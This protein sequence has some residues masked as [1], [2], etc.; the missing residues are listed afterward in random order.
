MKKLFFCVMVLS[1]IAS[2][3]TS[4]VKDK[5]NMPGTY[6]M[7]SQTLNDGTRETKF[8]DLKQLKIYTDD[9]MMYVQV[10][11][12]D[13]ISA[14]G[15]GTYTADTGTVTE[16]VI[17]SASDSNF[18]SAP[19]TFKLNITK[20]TDG[21]KQV[22]P[23]IVTDSQNYKLT[24]IYQKVGT[25]TKTPL[26]GV[27]KEV[28]SYN[29]RGKDTLKTTRTQYKGFYNG[30]FMFGHTFID[31]VA[32]KHT[33]IGFGTF[34]MVNDKKIKE[35][36]LNSTYSI[37]AGNTFDIDIEMTGTDQYKQTLT[38]ADGTIGVEYYERLKK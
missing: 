8:T 19:S 7:T 14:F 18:V 38:N 26:D 12:E 34:Q 28:R 5:P 9:F 16:N 33:G 37:I 13:S 27:W 17:Y 6:L 10:N 35:T 15:V 23:Q 4:S 30:Y 29:L 3:N 31:S 25:A 20:T 22:I 32:K 24:E 2:C 21:Y 1:I 11:P 36:D